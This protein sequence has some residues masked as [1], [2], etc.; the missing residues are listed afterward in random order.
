MTPEDL[1]LLQELS[2]IDLC[3]EESAEICDDIAKILNYMEKLSEVKTDHVQPSSH[4]ISESLSP[5]RDDEIGM[6]IPTKEFLEN[7]PSH[8]SS[9]IKVPTVIE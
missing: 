8:I 5:L 2:K 4:A 7:S 3:K 1:D 9:F 6:M